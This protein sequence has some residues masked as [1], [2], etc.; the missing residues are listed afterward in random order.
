VSTLRNKNRTITYI[1]IEK[2]GYTSFIL[3]QVV[4][5]W[6]IKLE[7]YQQILVINQAFEIW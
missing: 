4:E 1:L 7:K 2:C 3:Q 6:V 5:M